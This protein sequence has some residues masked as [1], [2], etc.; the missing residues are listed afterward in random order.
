[1]FRFTCS[2]YTHSW[3]FVSP[4]QQTIILAVSLRLLNINSFLMFR[5]AYSTYTHFLVFRFT[6][7][8]Y[9]HSWCLVSPTQHKLILD[10]S[11]HLLNIHSFFV[12]RFTCSTYTHY[13]VFRFA[14]STC[15]HS[16]CFASPTQHKLIPDVSFC[17]QNT[18][19]LGVSFRLLNINSFL[20]LRFTYSTYTH[21][22]CFVSPAQNTLILGVS[23]HL[24][25]RQSFLLFR[26]A[27]ST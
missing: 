8:T 16:C 26:F 15:T 11:F 7:S 1:M 27:Y 12:F 9:T 3:C 2:K 5:F 13:L 18:L 25:N 22:L 19:I 17:L 21:S 6:Y 4:T 24:L 10:V 20:L 14:Y 23:F